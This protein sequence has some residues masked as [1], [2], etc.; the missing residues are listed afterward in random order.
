MYLLFFPINR[1]GFL[2]LFE[3]ENITYRLGA[4]ALEG[5]AAALAHAITA[6]AIALIFWGISRFL[7]FYFLPR[8]Q[9]RLAP[10]RLQMLP[11]LLD[12]FAPVIPMFIWISGCYFGLIALPWSAAC[13]AAAMGGLLLVYR[14]L[15][16]VL[17]GR[18]LW[19]AAPV[20]TLVLGSAANRL[21]L[22]TNRTLVSVL[23]K[24]FRVCVLALCAITILDELGYPVTG[25]VTGLGL[26]GLTFSLAA[27]DSA[28]NMF[29]GIMIL[30]EK[31]FG[32]G[33]WIK[34]GDV[35]GTVEDLTFR[36]TKVRALDNSLYVLPNSSVSSATINNGTNRTK[37][38][39]RFTL[40]VTYDTTR[41][42]LEAL[43]ADLEKMLK[44]RCEVETDSV[45]VRL[46]G[47]GDSS[48]DILVSCYVETAEMPRFLAIQNSLNLDIMDVMNRNGVGFAFPST[49]VYIEKKAT[50]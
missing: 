24:V 48:I 47:F 25:L 4:L 20:C 2:I 23:E 50:E 49:S 21:D 37:R 39:F 34:V 10:T 14:L 26:T 1:K 15:C 22:K 41:P 36:S 5:P 45:T 40:G 7:K 31:P 8:L 33:D 17:L 9:K 42:Q 38:L 27:K 13:Q 3:L 43:M 32:I 6:S 12:G 44:G 16:I 30:L 29:S 35:E 28:S 11:A 46:T 19:G 18:G